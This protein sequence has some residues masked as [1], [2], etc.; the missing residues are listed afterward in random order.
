[1]QQLIY[2][3]RIPKDFFLTKGFG[4]SQH[5]QKAGSLYLAL[6]SANIEKYNIITTSAFLSKESNEV[7]KKDLALGSELETIMAICH[8]V[9]DQTIGAGVGFGWLHHKE[10]DEKLCGIVTDFTGNVT[11]ETVKKHLLANLSEIY[12]NSFHDLYLLKNIKL[13]SIDGQVNHK[14]GSCLA[15]ICFVNYI[16][17]LN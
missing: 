7:L 13:V 6:K 15:A 12:L 5:S 2:Q 9:K 14:F 16:Y 17:K 1:M 11:K 3:N 4:E 8:G 10:T